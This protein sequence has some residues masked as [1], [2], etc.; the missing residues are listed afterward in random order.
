MN[1]VLITKITFGSCCFPSLWNLIRF[2][3]NYSE[4]KKWKR[5]WLC[6]NWKYELGYSTFKPLPTCDTVCRNPLQTSTELPS[7]I[8]FYLQ[9]IDPVWCYTLERYRKWH[10]NMLII[11]EW[12]NVWRKFDLNFIHVLP[13]LSNKRP[14]KKMPLYF[15]ISRTFVVSATKRIKRDTCIQRYPFSRL[16]VRIMTYFLFSVHW[17]KVYWFLWRYFFKLMLFCC[18][19]SYIEQAGN[20]IM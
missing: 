4:K 2:L 6:K 12:R 11:T 3:W 13:F 20:I 15:M 9:F 8:K 17:K 18:L 16:K 1:T 7:H 14:I 19:S 5:N 10:T